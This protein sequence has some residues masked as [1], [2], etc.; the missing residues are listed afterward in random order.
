VSLAPLLHPPQCPVSLGPHFGK[1]VSLTLPCAQIRSAQLSNLRSADVCREDAVLVFSSLL[2]SRAFR[3]RDREEN[4]VPYTPP[5]ERVLEL[6][7]RRSVQQPAGLREEVDPHSAQI[8]IQRSQHAWL[9][10]EPLSRTKVHE[11]CNLGVR[12]RWGIETGRLVEKRH[13][14]QHEHG[15]SYP[16]N[17]MRGYP[18]LMRLGHLNNLLAQYSERP[19]CQAGRLARLVYLRRA[20]GLIQFIRETSAGLWLD[21]E[22]IRQVRTSPSQLRP[23]C[24]QAGC[25]EATPLAN[26]TSPKAGPEGRA[27][28]ENQTSSPRSASHRSRQPK[29]RPKSSPDQYSRGVLVVRHG[30]LTSQA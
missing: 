18:F 2:L 22:R 5:D 10:S 7:R 12:H 8:V 19:A 4:S 21:A 3:S 9:S 25:C 15:F 29:P 24:R 30:S 6:H 17:A 11:R 28:P 1:T 14:Y 23:A 20:R 16:W 26:L 13:G 27:F